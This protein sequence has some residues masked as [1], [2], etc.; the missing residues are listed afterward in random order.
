MTHPEPHPDLTVYILPI[1]GPYFPLQLTG[2]HRVQLALQDLDLRGETQAPD[3]VLASSGGAVVGALGIGAAWRPADLLKRASTLSASELYAKPSPILPSLLNWLLTGAVVVPARTVYRVGQRNLRGR[4]GVS[5]VAEFVVGTYC[6][7]THAAHLFSGAC[8]GSGV[9]PEGSVNTYL[10]SDWEAMTRAVVASAAV[11]QLVPA[12]RVVKNN[13]HTY[14]DGGIYA[15]SPWSSVWRQVVGHPG[16][17]KI[18]YFVSTM[19][20]NDPAFSCMATLAAMVNSSS[21]REAA[22]LVSAFRMRCESRGAAVTSEIYIDPA[23]AVQSFKAAREAV[24]VIRPYPDVRKYNFNL[25]GFTG[26][27]LA[28]V[29]VRFKDIKYEVVRTA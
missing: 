29:V 12:I 14:Q 24:L 25:F 6:P 17:L 9:L 23:A 21:S 28:S 13:L 11:P 19:I 10:G 15:P 2:L 26:A 4:L 22:D 1:S 5:G 8:R 3:L 18:A 16:R 27:Q 7:Q 20:S